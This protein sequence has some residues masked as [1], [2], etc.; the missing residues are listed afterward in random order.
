MS[1]TFILRRA[2][3]IV[4]TDDRERVTSAINTVQRFGYALGAAAIGIVA[5]RA[6]MSVNMAL[7]QART[8]T[9]IVFA[10]TL[11]PALAGLVGALRFVRFEERT[12]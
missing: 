4:A 9:L 3:A 5:N 2:V 11:L 1:W 7:E 6:G 12:D 8:V 10:L